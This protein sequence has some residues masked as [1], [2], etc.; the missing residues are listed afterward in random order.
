MTKKMLVAF[1]IV[2]I[3]APQQVSCN[4]KKS[5]TEKE[6]ILVG[7]DY[8]LEMYKIISKIPKEK[9]ISPVYSVKCFILKHSNNFRQYVLNKIDEIS[10][11]GK[12]GIPVIK[13]QNKINIDIREFE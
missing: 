8:T 13:H 6:Y 2:L 4:R 11:A 7:D 3:L 12:N 1:I 10:C 5:G 9:K